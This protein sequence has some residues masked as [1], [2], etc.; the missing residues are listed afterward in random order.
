MTARAFDGRTLL[1]VGGTSGFGREVA[2]RAADA[3]ARLVVVGRDEAKLHRVLA[4]L[5]AA[6]ATVDGHALDVTDDGAL[7]ELVAGSGPVDHVVSTVGGAM[8]GGFLDAPW[9]TI[10]AAVEEK[11]FDNLRLARAVAPRVTDGGSMVFTAGTGGR[12]EGASGAV[13]GNQ[14]IGTMV[15]GLAAELAPR[16]VRVNAV[17]P[18]WTPTPLWRDVPEAEVART[19]A[20]MSAVI[21]LGRTATVAEVA[22]AYLFLLSHTFVTG[23]TLPVDGGM[24]LV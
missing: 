4:D 2:H 18:T 6:G 20:D 15:R 13:V 19:R 14:A 8:G 9:G 17:A 23:H 12:P 10:R 7:A 11:L 21:P 24:H 5:R 1:V 22:D 16:R 3:G